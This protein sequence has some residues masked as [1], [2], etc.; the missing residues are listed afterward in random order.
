VTRRLQ[1]SIR[2]VREAPA[3]YLHAWSAVSTAAAAA[4]ARAWLFR[5]TDDP[6]IYIEFIEWKHEAAGDT[7]W[8]A[9]LAGWADLDRFGAAVT[10]QWQEP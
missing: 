1:S 8:S 4:G 10:R 6:S 7:D 3:D 5:A 9:S 2:S